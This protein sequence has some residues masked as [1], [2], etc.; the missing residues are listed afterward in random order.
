MTLLTDNAAG[1]L[2]MSAVTLLCSAI[3]HPRMTVFGR[4]ELETFIHPRLRYSHR[5][6]QS[7]PVPPL[8]ALD[9]LLVSAHVLGTP[10]RWWRP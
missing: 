2:S 1:K 5:G 6:A 8:Q 9:E 7:R 10:D 3:A 4:S